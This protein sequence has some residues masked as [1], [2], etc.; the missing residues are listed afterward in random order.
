MFQFDISNDPPTAVELKQIHADLKHKR[1]QQIKLSCLSDLSHTAVFL[2]LYFFNLLSGFGTLTAIVLGTLC[3][4]LLATTM[5]DELGPSQLST[6]ALVAIGNSLAVGS[7]LFWLMK[8]PL[9]GS[10]AAALTC[11]SI[12]FL[13]ATLGRRIKQVMLALENLKPMTDDDQAQHELIGLCRSFPQLAQ[14]REQAARLLRPNLTYGELAAM[15]QWV[16]DHAR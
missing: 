12:V 10:I 7:I 8:Q 2:A 14:Y 9:S 4:L 1:H 5:P 6:V 16:R 11:A 3:A 15:R 13:G